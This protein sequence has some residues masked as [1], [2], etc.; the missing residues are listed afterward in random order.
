MK[1]EDIHLWDVKRIIFGIAPP[2]FLLEVFIRTLV[3]YVVAIIVMRWMG[4]RMTGLQT[5]IELSVIVMMGAIICVAMQIPDRG[6]LQGVWVLLITLVLLRSVNWLGFKS[7]KFENILQG[8]AVA[9]IKDGVLQKPELLKTKISNQQLFEFL[10]SH[11]VFNLGMVK[12]LYLEGCGIFSLYMREH[13]DPG[14]PLYPGS[15]REV[16]DDNSNIAI[17]VKACI[18]CGTVQSQETGICPVCGEN[19]WAKAIL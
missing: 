3:V 19:A 6:I 15:D 12:R 14:L 1:Q 16:Y 18:N 17:G 2:E 5:I 7:P 10:R 11:N 13:P 4:K 8:K 9:L